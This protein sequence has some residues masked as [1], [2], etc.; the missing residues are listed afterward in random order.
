MTA[1]AQLRD[2]AAIVGIAES[3]YTKWGK[4]TDRSEFQLALEVI[5]RAVEEAGLSLDD[6]DGFSSFSNDRNEASLVATALGLRELRYADMTWITGGGGACAAVG[7]AAMAIATGVADCVVVY[8]SICMGEFQRF[9]RPLAADAVRPLDRALSFALP[10]GL[11]NATI[12]MALLVR[13]H[14]ELY[15]TTTRQLGS[16]AV[17]CRAHANSN[18]AAVMHGR[19]MTLEDHASSRMI[20]EPFRLF[21]CCLETDGAC[22]LVLVSAERA[23]DLRNRAVYV[24]GA[25]QGMG[26]QY[27]I[28]AWSMQYMPEEDYA[29]G[30]ATTIA[31]NLYAAAGVG[32]TDV[33]VVQLYDHY[34]GM[35][36]LGLEDFGFCERGEGGPLVESGAIAWPDGRLPLNTAGGSLSEAYIHGLNHVVEGVKQLRGTAINQVAD[37]EVCLVASGTGIPTSAVILRR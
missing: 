5:I 4:I 30:G 25:A 1:P 7:N 14:M 8:R 28:G 32:P 16:V 19:P 17:T 2:R 13:R 24:R 12:G 21:D 3:E 18:P 36:I 9:G 31:R 20:V 11:F 37:S 23:R 35:V 22:A 15:G 34:T 10:F 6:V 26:R 27:G 33:D 29:T